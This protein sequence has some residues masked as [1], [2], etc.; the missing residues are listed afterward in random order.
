[1]EKHAIIIDDDLC[2]R[3]LVDKILRMSGYQTEVYASP[4]ECPCLNCG[5]PEN[6]PFNPYP[7]IL[8]TDI[9]M[10]GM[11]GIDFVAHIREKHCRIPK[12][13]IMSGLWN[14]DY[15]NRCENLQV[16]KFNKPFTFAELQDWISKNN[17]SA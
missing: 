17:Q 11:N 7:E 10:P 12:I 2:V 15:H 1:M 4:E 13:G 16:V 5:C 6:C 9:S 3:K 8:L 14:D